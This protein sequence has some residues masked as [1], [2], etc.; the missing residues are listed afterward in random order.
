MKVKIALVVAAVV[1][2][3]ILVVALSGGGPTGPAAPEE[4]S[5]PEARLTAGQSGKAARAREAVKRGVEWMLDQQKPDGSW[6]KYDANV[7]QTALVVWALAASPLQLREANSAEVKKAVGFMLK[8]RHPDGSIV[9]KGQGLENYNTSM[10]VLA[11]V[12][13]ENPSHLQVIE[14]ARDY[15][16]G[17]QVTGVESDPKFGGIGYGS[18]KERGPDMSNTSFA[19]E[20]LRAAGLGEDDPAF[21][22]ALVFVR[23]CQNLGETNDQPA[24]QVA[25]DPENRG[26]G[27]YRPMIGDDA[28]KAG[29]IEKRGK[30]GWKSYG[31]MTYAM[32]MGFIY[33]GAAM[34]SP[35]VKGAME[36][37]TN[38]YTLEENPGMKSQGLYY[39]YHTFAKAM[40]ASGVGKIKDSEGVEHD[41]AEELVAKLVSLQKEDGHWENATSRWFEADPTLVT[42]YTIRALTLAV[43]EI[44]SRK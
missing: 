23:R 28:S 7:G 34:D 27:V 8:H 22:R 29:K 32:L 43:E 33:C 15:V 2:V 21:K 1:A 30:V 10:A 14:K 42:A 11:L 9:V 25:T 38:N 44:E 18:H 40:R 17:I 12:A 16:V 31:S 6:G 19:I 39:Y 24:A 36:W 37:I 35:E 41:W 4:A 13:L 20:A 26:G 3:V 5:G